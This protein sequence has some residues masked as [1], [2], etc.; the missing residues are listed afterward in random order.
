ESQRKLAHD[1]MKTGLS[2]KGYMTATS[3]MA[4]EDVLRGIEA[5]TGDPGAGGRRFARDPLEYHVSVF[6]TPSAKGMWGWR[7]EGHH[8]ALHFAVNNGTAVASTPTF[9]GSNPAEVREGPKKGTRILGPQEDAARALVQAL[10]DGQRKTAILQ[11]AALGEIVT[12]NN[13]K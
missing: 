8:V 9:F 3:I 1:L 11:P 6:G 2:Q 10:D 5:A 4:L 13:V 12:R 7:V